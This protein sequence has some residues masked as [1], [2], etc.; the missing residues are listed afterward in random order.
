[1]MALINNWDLK[2]DNNAVYGGKNA[3]EQVYEVSDLGASFGTTGLSFPFSRSKLE[4]SIR[5][6]TPSLSGKVSPEYV[7]FRTPSRPALIY[8]FWPPNF[9]H[10]ARLDGVA[11][12]IPRADVR[13][14]AHLLSSLSPDQIRDAFRAAGYTQQQVDAFTKVVQTRI[15]E[16][17][18]L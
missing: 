11:H 18:E 10:R 5:M 7:D 3:G 16:L 15:I 8:A 17:S 2:D 6:F 4:T 9:L 12:H 1:M 13:W 14:I